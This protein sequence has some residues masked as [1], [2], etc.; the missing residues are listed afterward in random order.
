M[1]SRTL[2]VRQGTKGTLSQE[3]GYMLVIPVLR[4]L[5]QEGL[6]FQDS[7]GYTVNARLA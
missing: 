5:R 4:K 2:R 3:W 7:L 6:K 1:L